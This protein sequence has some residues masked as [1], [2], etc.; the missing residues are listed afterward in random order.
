MQPADDGGA[1]RA[2][3]SRQLRRYGPLAAIVVLLVVVAAV[4]VVGGG[5]DGGGDGDGGSSE[6]AGA[7][8]DLRWSEIGDAEPGAPDP[9]GDMPVTYAEADEAGDVD[10]HEWPDT[11]D[12]ERGTV[13]LPSVYAPPCVPA[14]EGDNGGATASG[15][16][17]D[18]IK[19]VY[20]VPQ[21]GADLDALLVS[22][23]VN[24]EPD[25]RV[26]TFEQYVEIGSSVAQTYGRQVE[27]VKFEASGT[28]VTASRADAIDVIAM[29]PF[30][31]INGPG[32]DRGTFA[33]EVTDAGI[34]CFSCGGV[35]PDQMVLDMAPYA[36]A[37]LPSPDQFL[38]MLG[39]WV[40][41]GAVAGAENV[42]EFAGGDIEGEPRKIGVIH[43]EQD[44]PIFVE[45]GEAQQERFQD[46]AITE[47]YL[48]DLATMPAKAT[49]LMAEY[50]SEGI[51]TVVF[52]GD[53]IMPGY[54]T[55][56]ATELEYFPE[57]LF[58]GTALTDTN[59]LARE[60]DPDQMV[61]AF[62]MSQLAAPAEQDL[63]APITLYRWY[64]GGDD[65]LPPARNQYAL[66]AAPAGWLVA[67]I[68]MA[69]PEL[70]A[71]TFARGLFRM[72]PAG[73]GPA[74]PQVSYGNWGVF[75]AM[76]YQ[77]VD[78]AVEIWWDPDVEAEDERGEVGKGVWR[79]SNGAARFTIED[80][81]EPK[82]FTD[83]ENS[84]TVLDELPE[85]DTPPD[86]P[87]PAGS[88]AAG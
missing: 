6:S 14:F 9:I 16:T 26:E 85:E 68:H 3:R 27:V 86:Y 74:N 44:P 17:G 50:K 30:A 48:F 12:T 25:E 38:G 73:G 13:K 24:D 57:W 56:A 4:V 29:D 66:Q 52:L 32:L 5:D 54:L 72:P 58:T 76:D 61:H 39:A 82:P 53:P 80:A 21:P 7:T 78:D 11:C 15:V 34:L 37:S 84:V 45:T 22:M 40:D 65:T 59:V 87:P 46:V 62:G 69:G 70:T 79:R 33:Q 42:A 67:G 23:G 18:T 64:F 63:Q 47:S 10:A 31:V 43:F 81:P 49:E 2:D 77:A 51:T 1:A 19:I 88:P 71:E 28:D 36:W 41:A 20:Y 35:L 75:P 60:W 8:G 55:D 83:A